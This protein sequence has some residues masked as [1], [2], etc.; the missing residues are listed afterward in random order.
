MSTFK[1][2]TSVT[3]NYHGVQTKHFKTVTFDELCA[4]KGIKALGR[5]AAQERAAR[6]RLGSIHTFRGGRAMQWAGNLKIAKIE[7]LEDLAASN[8]IAGYVTAWRAINH[9]TQ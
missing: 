7:P 4:F 8:D 9:L 1:I 5:S 2:L 6:A 3:E